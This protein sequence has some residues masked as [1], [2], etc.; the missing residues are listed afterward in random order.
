MMS[1]PEERIGECK[2]RHFRMLRAQSFDTKLATPDRGIFL[3]H[4]STSRKHA[5]LGK[6]CNVAAGKA[7]DPA[8]C[9]EANACWNHLGV[10]HWKHVVLQLV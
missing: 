9:A 5:R 6:L 4:A 8:D 3:A 7:W 1:T 2:G 10:A